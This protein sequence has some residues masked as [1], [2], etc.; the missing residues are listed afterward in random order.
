MANPQ[1]LTPFPQKTEKPLAKRPIS[2]KL[3]ADIDE[4]VRSLPDT[5]TWLRRVITEAAQR[6][7]K[8]NQCC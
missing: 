3:E 6:E 7:L 5:S 2:V 8:D 4:L 1:N